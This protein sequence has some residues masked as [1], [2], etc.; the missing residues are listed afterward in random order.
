[1]KVNKPCRYVITFG[2]DDLNILKICIVRYLY[3]L[4]V[5][6]EYFPFNYFIINNKF[7]IYNGFNCVSFVGWIYPPS[8]WWIN[9]PYAFLSLSF[10]TRLS[11]FPV[12]FLGSSSIRWICLGILKFARCSLIYFFKF[13]SSKFS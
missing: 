10:K 2:I 5:K 9:P 8:K 13:D 7:C 6:E 4:F 11:T 12:A 1:M 3:N